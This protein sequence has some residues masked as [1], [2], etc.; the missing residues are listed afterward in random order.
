MNSS[1]DASALRQDLH[2]LPLPDGRGLVVVDDIGGRF[3]RTTKRIWQTLQGSK[4]QESGAPSPS[5][6]MFWHQAKA[7][8]WLKRTDVEA[9]T[10]RS[11][12]W[13][14]PLSFRIPLASIDPVARRLVPISG[15]VFS[16]LAVAL[17]SIAG[18][19]SLLFWMVRW[20]QWAGSV[21]SLQTYLASLQPLTIA[22][23][24]V[25][26]KTAHELGHA[27]LCRRLGSRCGV[28]G[29]WWLC[30]MPC[31]YVD[32]TDVWRQPNAARRGAVMAAGIWVEWIIAMVALWVWW[33][34]PSHEVRMTAMNVVLVC[35][36][37][38]VLFNANP[39][40]RYDGYFILSDLLDSPNLREEARRGLRSLLVSP[41]RRWHRYGK[42]VWSLAGYHIASK[43]YRISISI[44]IATFIL[45]WAVGWGLWRIAIVVV[46]FAV[47]RYAIGGIR[48][49]FRMIR[50]SGTWTGVPGG[51]RV[52]LAICF[53]IAVVSILMV[54]FPRYRHITGTVR[55]RDAVL[56]YLP[57]GGVIQSVHVRVGDRVEMGQ[58]LAEVSD[59]ALQLKLEKT[60]GQ[61]SVIQERVHAMRLASLRTGISS[62]DWQ[63]LEAASASLSSSQTQL[64]NRVDAL[65]LFSPK[66]G[67]VLASSNSATPESSLR[68]WRMD[69]PFTLRPTVGQTTE[70]RIPWCRIASDARLEVV[71]EINASDR[72]RIAKDS[73]V[74]LTSSSMPGRKVETTVRVVSPMELAS[75]ATASPKVEEESAYE[76]VCDFPIGNALE[77]HEA[78]LRANPSTTDRELDVLLRWDGASCQAV[79]RLPPQ[80]L[81]KDAKHSIER[82]MG[83]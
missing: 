48:N 39:L 26:T 73:P 61:H 67:L 6:S 36:V 74:R 30:F 14:S 44:A 68:D 63:T 4:S 42:R 49:L 58:P 15:L 27:V 59:P 17:F 50:G 22:A 43:L 62:R 40:M 9:S 78:G 37:S 55:V 1:H 7:A 19:V 56:V 54:P 66:S 46:A 70:D 33:L 81:W 24:F 21:P 71:L 75:E 77:P 32:V 13:H 31:P 38:T 45:Q 25:L 72:D 8:G 29:V 5:D 83:I 47:V 20:Q 11:R 53:C 2:A 65:S 3:A 52:G 23:T 82:L 10:A 57:R 12:W 69:D 34:A 16:P 28:I 79:L 51:R 76:A 18:L 60:R 64:Q 35:G 80:P 41:V